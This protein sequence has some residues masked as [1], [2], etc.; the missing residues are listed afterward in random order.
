MV[1]V[2]LLSVWVAVEDLFACGLPLPPWVVVLWATAAPDA[3]TRLIAIAKV[4]LL[5]L[6]RISPDLVW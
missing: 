5:V 1:F 4:R 2:L 3:R 6:I